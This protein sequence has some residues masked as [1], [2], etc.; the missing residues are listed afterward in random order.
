[1]AYMAVTRTRSGTEVI[2]RRFDILKETFLSAR[3]ERSALSIFFGGGGLD[4]VV[5][6]AHV[7]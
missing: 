6:H 4:F 3:G 2:K 5:K 1:M 7:V